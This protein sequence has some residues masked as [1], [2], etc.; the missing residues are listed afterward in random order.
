ML[1][2]GIRQRDEPSRENGANPGRHHPVA[3]VVRSTI[4]D[5]N[6]ESANQKI[7]DLALKQAWIFRILN[8]LERERA[9]F[10]YWRRHAP[11][12]Q[13]QDGTVGFS[14]VDSIISLR[15]FVKGHSRIQVST[16]AWADGPESMF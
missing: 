11:L 14:F 9:S 6:L 7:C 2:D 10:R 12:R 13:K 15:E 16:R 3:Q 1:S 4:K 5:F 8:D